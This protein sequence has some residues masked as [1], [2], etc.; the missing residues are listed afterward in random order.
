[1]A[2]LRLLGLPATNTELFLLVIG[3]VE[4]ADHT[5]DAW[6]AVVATR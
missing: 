2:R 1:M 4:L 5:G 6:V 3:F